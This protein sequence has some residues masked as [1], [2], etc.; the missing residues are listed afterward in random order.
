SVFSGI[1]VAIGGTD[2]NPAVF[3]GDW[4]ITISNELARSLALEGSEIYSS[5]GG[6]L[7]K[8]DD[9]T[10]YF[11]KGDHLLAFPQECESYHA[12]LRATTIFAVAFSTLLLATI[13]TLLGKLK[14]TRYVS[15]MPY[16]ISEAFLACVGYKVFYYAIK[17]CDFDPRQFF[18]AAFIGIVLYFIKAL[19]IGNPTIMTMPLGLLLPLAIFW[20]VALGT[21]QTPEMMRDSGWLFPE[22]QNEPFYLVWLDSIGSTRNINFDAWAATL[23]DL[24]VML[25]V[26]TMD[27][28]LKLHATESKLP[29][30]VSTDDEALTFGLFNYL[31]AC[32]G[33]AT[34][35]MQLKF[36]VISYGVMRNAHD[37]RAG[38][39]FAMLCGAAYFSTVEHFNYLPK[40]FL[41]ALLFFA[42]AGFV[43]DNMWGSRK[44][45]HFSE[46]MEIVVIL[47]VFIAVGQSMIWAV[48]AGLVLSAIA[49]IAKYARVPSMDGLPKRGDQVVT[50][51]RPVGEVGHQSFMHIASAWILIVSLKGYVFFSS[52]VQVMRS[53]E[54]HF[55]KEDAKKVPG[56]RRLKFLVFD[57]SALDGM[58][59]SGAM[60][61][62]KLSRK[63]KQRGMRVIWCNIKGNLAEELRVRSILASAED[64]FE[65]LDM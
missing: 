47:I 33:A 17:F 65:D 45:L 7:L 18:T 49:F 13:W 35:Y 2:L 60:C 16:S 38:M 8:K 24:G 50:R 26:S 36:N 58:D 14:L 59:A 21:Q 32:C 25:I 31:L 39:I 29:L 6:R 11:C 3:Y 1:P 44:F 22:V 53:V 42:G 52:C 62:A 27:C 57:G 23:P 12:Q 30:K 20:G 4:V 63:A 34:G 61:M 15:Y 9:P 54:E 43:T 64:L 28:I 55:Q 10:K 51:E 5:S 41:S 48:V 40:L 56:Y 46:W 19:H 37:R